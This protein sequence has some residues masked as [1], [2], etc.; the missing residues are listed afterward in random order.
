M[1][2]DNPAAAFGLLYKWGYYLTMEGGTSTW[3]ED[4]TAKFIEDNGFR[5]ILGDT[6]NGSKHMSSHG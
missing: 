6:C 3:A 1:K 4:E 2:N 5:V